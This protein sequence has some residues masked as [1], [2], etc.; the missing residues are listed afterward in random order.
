MLI[1]LT[2]KHS[3]PRQNTCLKCGTCCRKNSPV[4][5]REDLELIRKKALLPENMILLRRGEPALDNILDRPILLEKELIKIRGKGRESWTCIFHDQQT[6]LCLI[7]RDRPLQC[8]TLECWNTRKI[9]ELYARDTLSRK[10]I[11][12]RNSALE[13]ITMMHQEKY[14]VEP[15]VEMLGLE[16]RSPGKAAREIKSMV[17]SDIRFRQAFQQK[18]RVRDDILEY[19]FGRSLADLVSPVTRFITRYSS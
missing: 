15:L 12:T 14:P 11:F 6:S 16:I 19:Y 5:H 7:H 4:L 3:D 9:T 18:T 13:E 1:D 10:D 8:R 17:T 2:M